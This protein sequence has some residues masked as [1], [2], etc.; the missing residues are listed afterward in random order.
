[1]KNDV[2]SAAISECA[3][4]VVLVGTA[5][6]SHSLFIRPE[7]GLPLNVDS[8]SPARGRMNKLWLNAAVP[9]SRIVQDPQ[10]FLV[11][12]RSASHGYMREVALQEA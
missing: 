11:Q 7:S 3:L 5:L 2:N 8:V 10:M 1:M 9:R 6:I 4:S 12:R